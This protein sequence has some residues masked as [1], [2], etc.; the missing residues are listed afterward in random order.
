MTAQRG[1]ARSVY[2]TGADPDDATLAGARREWLEHAQS[3]DAAAP[4]VAAVGRAASAYKAA[5]AEL[6][7]AVGRAASA[8]GA[9]WE[10]IGQAA[11]ITGQSAHERW[12]HAGERLMDRNDH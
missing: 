7:A 9:S 10:T 8:A 1:P 3:V 11:G 6:H 12:A 5:H 2:T 4:A